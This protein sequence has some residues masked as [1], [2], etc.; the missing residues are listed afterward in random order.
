MVALV[1]S[2]VCSLLVTAVAITLRP[3][4]ERNA[5]LERQRNILA[6][7]GRL[8][9][10][11]PIPQQ[12]AAI[13]PRVVDLATGDY[14]EDIDPRSFDPLALASDPE[15]GINIPAEADVAGI[16]RRARHAI[17]Y[18]V[19]D[20]A[21]EVETVIF[22]VH[23]QGLW[24]TMYGLL[25]LDTDGNTVEALRF[26]QHEETPGLGDQIDRET[27]LSQWEGKEVY[28][29]EG[30]PRIE[31]MRSQAGDSVFQVDGLAGA[32]LTGRGVTNL[33]RYWLGPDGYGP[34]INR[35]WRKDDLAMAGK[36]IGNRNFRF[37]ASVGDGASLSAA[38]TTEEA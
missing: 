20:D 17:I 16:K 14:A 28:D 38:K 4:Q 35:H 26:Y 21:G 30:V 22:P 34:Y 1:V 15:E 19:R 8:D 33:M 10:S 2:L 37:A 12:F 13:E 24:S 9:P 27:W 7:A 23:G 31:V 25:A 18:L 3:A 36:R 11:Q 5:V 6:V 32:T 29:A